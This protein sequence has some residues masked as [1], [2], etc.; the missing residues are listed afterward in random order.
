MGHP[1]RDQLGADEHTARGT[2]SRLVLGTTRE[3]RRHRSGLA[4]RAVGADLRAEHPLLLHPRDEHVEA[5][6]VA[7]LVGHL[8]AGDEPKRPSSRITSSASRLLVV[9]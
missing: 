5:I 4:P 8:E 2:V 3:A 1:D 9:A 7:L 6:A